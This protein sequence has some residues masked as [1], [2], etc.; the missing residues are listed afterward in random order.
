MCTRWKI[1][2]CFAVAVIL[3]GCVTPFAERVAY[4]PQVRDAPGTI[5]LSDPK[6]YTREALISERARDIKWINRLISDSEDSTKVVFK[7]ELVREV[8]QI[9]AMAAAIGLKFDP[10]A[11]LDYRHNK[12]TGDIQHEIDVL[13][14]QLQLDQ[15]K[16]DA[17]LVRANFDSQIAPVNEGIGMLNDT[18]AQNSATVTASAAD[19][20]KAAIEKLNTTLTS[21]LDADSK[22]ASTTTVTSS[23]FDDFR[24]RSAYRD[25]LKAAYNAAGL[26]QLHDYANARLIRLN[27]Q[28]SALPDS[29]NMQ[30]LGAIQLHV[31]APS[32]ES[33]ATQQFF[34]HWLEYIN[35]SKNYPNENYRSGAKLNVQNS[36]IQKLLLSGSFEKVDVLGYEL[37]LPFVID[38]DGQ[39]Q[40]PSNIYL[41]S[42]WDTS[43]DD[44]QK[45]YIEATSALSSLDT[46]KTA[47]ILS[48][49]CGNRSTDKSDLINQRIQEAADRDLSSEYIQ[50]ANTVA[51]SIG[52]PTILTM[53]ITTNLNNAL[54]FRGQVLELMG[55]IQPCK[56]YSERLTAPR[57]WKALSKTAMLGDNKIRVYE[58]GPREQVQQVS[59]AARSASSLAL[60]ASLAASN[61]RLRYRCGSSRKLLAPGDGTRHSP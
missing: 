36:T 50:L 34:R 45:N 14:L 11:A 32:L 21:R 8:E 1:A 41:R 46:Q 42:H 18:S 3:S 58:I 5:T 60:A 15:L 29:D 51:L 31:V 52:K 16:R 28:A 22:P 19:Q 44:D 40:S 20:L 38:G 33:P 9:T 23:P 7:P 10:S 61:P 55:K 53:N 48:N 12:E 57:I 4:D 59:T 43:H 6:L 13:K 2:A 25:M 37:L 56:A 47:D 49:I 39:P 26:D 35:T 17:D 54:D 27:F 30:S 24:D